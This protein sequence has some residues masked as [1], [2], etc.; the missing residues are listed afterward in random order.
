M[1]HLYF[2]ISLFRYLH[3]YYRLE[4]FEQELHSKMV[5]PLLDLRGYCSTIS[6]YFRLMN[7]IDYSQLSLSDREYIAANFTCEADVEQNWNKA[8]SL[9]I[10]QESIKQIYARPSGYTKYQYDG[11]ATENVE[12]HFFASN[13]APTNYITFGAYYTQF[14]DNMGMDEFRNHN[15]MVRVVNRVQDNEKVAML[16]FSENDIFQRLSVQF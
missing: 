11:G 1:N 12:P 8:E 9:G 2:E 15:A 14:E 5:K 7:H 6:Q 3:A 10:Y 16:M 4:Q 13:Y